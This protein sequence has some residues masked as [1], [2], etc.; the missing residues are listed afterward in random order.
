MSVYYY[1]YYLNKMSG[2][3]LFVII[4]LL[5]IWFELTTYTFIFKR[6]QIKIVLG[7]MFALKKMAL[8]V[9]CGVVNYLLG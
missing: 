8:K 6:N 7:F 1:Y 3:Y 2:Y 5:F 4:Y 9:W